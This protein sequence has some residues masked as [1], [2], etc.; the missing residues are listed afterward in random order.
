M[1]PLGCRG[2]ELRTIWAEPHILRPFGWTARLREEHGMRGGVG[3]AL[4]RPLETQS[5]SK[6][7]KEE[8]LPHEP[9]CVLPCL[10]AVSFGLR[11]FKP[12]LVLRRGR[13]S[14]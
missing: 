1:T 9:H 14:S 13:P 4:H 5:V 3:A 2:S 7:A 10:F 6:D 8:R 11:S 12:T